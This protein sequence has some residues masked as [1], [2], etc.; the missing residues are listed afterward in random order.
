M[1]IYIYIIYIYIYNYMIH[2]NIHALLPGV[3]KQFRQHGTPCD[4]HPSKCTHLRVFHLKF[5][6]P[7]LVY[8]GFNVLISWNR[9]TPNHPILVGF[10]LTKTI[11]LWGYPHFRKAPCGLPMFFLIFTW[12]AWWI[13]ELDGWQSITIWQ[14]G[15]QDRYV[16]TD[17][18]AVSTFHCGE[19]A[20]QTTFI[21]AGM[22]SWAGKKWKT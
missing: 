22:V 6:G 10:S 9:G 15:W 11:Q 17:I 19:V 14:P 8:E 16:T 20:R 12:P 2:I 21:K 13:Y 4:N 18:V 7:K 3:I 5:K 1:C